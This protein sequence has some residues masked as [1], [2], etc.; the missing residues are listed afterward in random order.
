M[1][2]RSEMQGKK[3]VLNTFACWDEFRA[4]LKCCVLLPN[5]MCHMPKHTIQIILLLLLLQ[6]STSVSQ[7]SEKT[8]VP[9]S[10]TRSSVIYIGLGSTEILAMGYQ[11]QINDEFGLGAKVDVLVLGGPGFFLPNAGVGGG[12]RA[13]YHFHPTGYD[14]FLGLNAFN[15]EASYVHPSISESPGKSYH[16]GGLELTIGHDAIERN[17]LG[18]IWAVGV[19]VSGSTDLPVLWLPAIKI[20]LHFNI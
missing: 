2:G 3:W 8:P 1:N 13:S 11:Y 5:V 6:A 17:G 7:S 4:S 9:G 12:V 15:F 18:L 10:E 20:G 14:N 16:A 19:G